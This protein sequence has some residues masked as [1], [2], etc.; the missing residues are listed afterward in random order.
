MI[1]PVR[2]LAPLSV[3][4]VCACGIGDVDVF[5][6]AP[7]PVVAATVLVHL[8]D[9]DGTTTFVEPGIDG[10]VLLPVG[11]WTGG[12]PAQ[13]TVTL[14]YYV[15][16]PQAL[17][18]RVG[19]LPPPTADESRACALANP[20]AVHQAALTQGVAEPW[21]EDLQR[22][23]DG[24]SQ[25]V[26]GTGTAQ[27]TLPDLCLRF[28]PMVVPLPGAAVI[29]YVVGI[30]EQSAL[31]GDLGET[32]WRVYVDGRFERLER[33]GGLPTR[34]GFRD[35]DG[36][37]WFSGDRGRVAHGPLEGPFTIEE[38]SPGV[39]FEVSSI[40]R[41]PVSGVILAVGI[42]NHMEPTEQVVI[43][44]RDPQ[45]WTELRYFEV[46]NASRGHTRIR[47]IGNGQALIM[48]GG[49][50]LFF[51]DG[52]EVR[53]RDVGVG[54]PLFGLD[55]SDAAVH[56]EHGVVFSDG[57]GWLYEGKAPFNNWFSVPGTNLGVA[58]EAVI[59]YAHG[60]V[61][62][63]VDGVVSQ[64]YP[65]GASCPRERFFD[66]DA[67]QLLQVGDAIVGSGSI[68]DTDFENSVTWLIPES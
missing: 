29:E 5:V 30:D 16:P 7:T 39:D 24:M 58:A 18:L 25:A 50:A 14:A 44:R 35:A 48:H 15:E 55:I 38:L 6:P 41:D 49:P 37:F 20:V 64:Y 27:C 4:F 9:D 60:Y 40:R 1:A 66:S 63:G 56:P 17:G 57:S 51:Y 3:V 34:S 10:T 13:A 43:M 68:R 62:G 26:V 31:I 21:I 11:R 8:S 53:L 67:D 28:K 23:P 54:D 12:P 2:R 36:T 61:Y 45:G 46:R 19:P 42:R 65:G 22:L 47:W 52:A 33:L 32:F 59:P